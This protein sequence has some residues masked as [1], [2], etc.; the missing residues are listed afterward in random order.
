VCW[1]VRRIPSSAAPLDRGRGGDDDKP[2]VWPSTEAPPVVAPCTQSWDRQVN[3]YVKWTTT[4]STCVFV[5]SSSATFVRERNPRFQSMRVSSLLL[6]SRRVFLASLCPCVGIFFIF[7]ATNPSVQILMNLQIVV[8]LGLG[9]I[10]EKDMRKTYRKERW[11]WRRWCELGG[12]TSTEKL[13]PGGIGRNMTGLQIQ[14]TWR[15]EDLSG[16]LFT[17]AIGL[18]SSGELGTMMAI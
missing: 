11:C 7:H 17:K 13:D 5:K 8:R 10:E 4:S 16:N 12:G 1:S 15:E 6:P 2:Y 3:D 9:R 18:V 14:R